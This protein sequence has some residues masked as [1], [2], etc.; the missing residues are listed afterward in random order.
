MREDFYDTTQSDKKES[1]E[2]GKKMTGSVDQHSEVDQGDILKKKRR[3]TRIELDKE[4]KR[5]RRLISINTEDMK[6]YRPPIDS[7]SQCLAKLF[8][9]YDPN[10]R[11]SDNSKI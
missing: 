9:S 7:R 8:D 10:Y 4:H 2:Q 3:K 11:H 6:F 1:S 5:I